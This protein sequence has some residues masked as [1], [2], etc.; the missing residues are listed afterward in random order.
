ME[1]S[2]ESDCQ[3]WETKQEGEEEQQRLQ[4]TE[5][6]LTIKEESPSPQNR[7][8]YPRGPTNCTR[9]I[10]DTDESNCSSVEST[11]QKRQLPSLPKKCGARYYKTKF[12]MAWIKSGP[13]KGIIVPIKNDS[14]FFRCL[15]CEKNVSCS[16]QGIYDV[17]RHVSGKAHRALEEKKIRN[18]AIAGALAEQESTEEW[19]VRQAEWN[20]TKFFA[21][22]RIP[23]AAADHLVRLIWQSFP[24]SKLAQSFAC[25]QARIASILNEAIVP[26]LLSN[27]TDDMRSSLFSLCID[28]SSYRDPEQKACPLT[29]RIFDSR[30]GRICC[31]FLDLCIRKFDTIEGVFATVCNAVYKHSIPLEN[32]VGFGLDNTSVNMGNLSPIKSM[33]HNYNANIYFMAC[34]CQVADNCA[35]QASSAFCSL[36]KDFDAEDLLVD[37]YCWFEHAS[38][39]TNLCGPFCKFVDSDY[40]QVLKEISVRW[41]GMLTGLDQLI[42]HF[43]SLRSYF[44]STPDIAGACESRMQRLFHCFK[45]PMTEIYCLFLQSSLPAFVNFN[46][47]LQR[48]DPVIH[49]LYDAIV[50]LLALL[51]SRAYV[52]QVVQ[53]FMK[54]PEASLPDL[55]S[56]D[57]Q[58]PDS[59][60]Y[61]GIGVRGK[62]K[63]MLEMGIIEPQTQSNF[64][65]AV[66]SFHQ[67]AVKCAL[68][69]L[70]VHDEVLKHAKVFNF[71]EKHKYGFE[72]VLFMVE[73]FNAYLKF[74]KKDLACLE[75]EFV[76]YKVIEFVDVPAKTWE[77]AAIQVT[78]ASGEVASYRID[79]IWF[80]LER[81]FIFRSTQRSKFFLLSKIARLLFTLPHSNSD[82]ERVFSSVMNSKTKSHEI[83]CDDRTSLSMLIFQTNRPRSEPLRYGFTQGGKKLAHSVGES[84]QNQD[85]SLSEIQYFKE[86]QGSETLI[87]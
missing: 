69:V 51:L 3:L 39:M 23:F 49:L 57:C 82:E 33:A 60:L 65:E 87:I 38:K 63:N 5:N 66:R 9:V 10:S 55:S 25:D 71:F 21:E 28:G 2:T 44:L 41:L 24:D 34:P 1:P 14:N 78:C 73:R 74:T 20:F 80:H 79:V 45:N 53:S 47:L 32:C 37:L 64:F 26:E 42:L 22:H 86:E 59:S 84:S 56:C 72:S 8:Q 48:E 7:P 70:P 19:I 36:L 81:D 17:K 16:H 43:D 40:C 12:D 67:A 83:S 54:N 4:R 46:L 61:V 11:S 31:K 13:F 18:K 58:I 52:G 68:E 35:L 75:Q 6:Y 62:L 29:V 77:D 27:L 76:T 15:I 85:R 30:Q 50:D